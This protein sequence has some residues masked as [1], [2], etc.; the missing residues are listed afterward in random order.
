MAISPSKRTLFVANATEN[1]I[2]RVDL[3]NG[4]T[5]FIPMDGEPTRVARVGDLLL[6]SLRGSRQVVGFRET[7]S[8]LEVVGRVSAGAEPVGVVGT[9]DGSTFY[10]A[11]SMSGVVTEFDAHEFKAVRAWEV[12]N[13]PRSVALHPSN[14]ALYVAST[15]GGDLYWI[16]LS[17]GRSSRIPLPDEIFVSAESGQGV[18]LPLTVRVTGDMAV[19]P[20]GEWLAIPVLYV[21]N[22]SPVKE[23]DG[24]GYTGSRRINPM[25]VLVALD[26][27]GRPESKAEA[28]TIFGSGGSYPSSVTFSPDGQLVVASME[29]SNGVVVFSPNTATIGRPEWP[30]PSLDFGFRPSPSL[31]PVSCDAGPTSVVFQDN[32]NAYV[33]AFLDRTVSS[34]NLSGFL[35]FLT[36]SSMTP[37]GSSGVGTTNRVSVAF[38]NLS[39]SVERGRRMFYS[40][41]DSRI[42][43][44]RSATSCATCHFE[45]RTDGLTWHFEER[46][47]R[48]TPS[49][50]GV[51]SE[52]EPVGWAGQEETVVKDVF[53]TSQRLMGGL[54][55][56]MADAEDVAEYVDWSRPVDLP[57][58]GSEDERA[59]RGREIFERPEVGCALCHHGKL[60]ADGEKHE[61][62]GFLGVKT[63]SL[64]GVAATAPYFHDGSSPTLRDVVLR[65]RIGGKGF[66]GDLSGQE[67][68]DLVYFLHTL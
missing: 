52:H 27:R 18:V 28:V 67:I 21:D 16:E 1:V 49:L 13:Q 30:R 61:L 12:P 43:R 58:K 9:Q 57:L 53:N 15:F 39:V 24:A 68:D 6:V 3:T 47:A 62:L 26:D 10:A 54:G 42:T 22:M 7:D 19:S 32:E 60:Y 35:S 59:M 66:T 45:G 8:M 40:A 38:S 34:M 55:L 33:Y 20:L 36:E 29:G 46:G 65:A 2:T 23:E 64:V 48:Q 50:A 11:A 37:V 17:S 31:I 4:L 25:V 56:T 63:P 44:L 5:E 14:R 41:N 51:V